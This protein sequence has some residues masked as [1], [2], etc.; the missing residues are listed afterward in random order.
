MRSRLIIGTLGIAAVFAGGLTLLLARQG[1]D[2]VVLDFETGNFSGWRTFKLLHPYSGRIVTDIVRR[3]RY[4]ARFELRAGDNMP[5][6]RGG[7]VRAELKDDYNAPLGKDYWYSFSTYIPNNF[8]L[9]KPNCVIAQWHGEH[10]DGEESRSPVLA[11]RYAGGDLII[12]IRYSSTKIQH[13]ND[14]T[15]KTLH[16]EKNFRRGVWHDFLYHVVWS[17]DDNG[18]VEGWLD[19]RQVIDYRGPVG[20]NDDEGPYFKFGLYHHDGP[21]PYVI[22]HDEYRRGPRRADV[23]PPA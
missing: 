9:R 7:G 18:R 21:D 2:A 17:P 14:G 15:R 1:P 22:Y 4:A 8:P 23:E 19:G 5:E 10:D 3:G 13:A 20:Y 16:E 11:H 12:D 6:D